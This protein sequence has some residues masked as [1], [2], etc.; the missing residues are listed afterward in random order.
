MELINS[1]K[2]DLKDYNF[3]ACIHKVHLV[4][5]NLNNHVH[6]TEFWKK[7]NQKEDI[8]QLACF[9]YEIIRIVTILYKPILPT[10]MSNIN[11]YIGIDESS[12]S[13]ANTDFRLFDAENIHKSGIAYMNEY[14]QTAQDGYFK[15]ETCYKNLI[16]VN[17]KKN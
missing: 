12:I 15:I 7:S 8:I 9:T 14:N 10:L 4:L 5:I 2:S 13:F 16:F 11:K 3:V 17:K 1:A 6:E